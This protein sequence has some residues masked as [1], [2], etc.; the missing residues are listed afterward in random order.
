[1]SGIAGWV[2]YVRELSHQDT[3]VRTMTA[4]MANRGPDHERVWTSRDAVLG[5]RALYVTD[6]E[7][8]PQPL[9]VA[10]DSDGRTAVVT[11][12][13]QLYNGGEL[14]TE[15]TGR[16]HGF[17]TRDD[18]EVIAHAYLEWGA[19]CVERFDGMFAIAIWDEQSRELVLARDRIGMKTLF[20]A[21]Q[22]TGVVFG[23]ERKTVLAHPQVDPVVDRRGLREL[24]SLAA[25]P[26]EAIFQGMRQ[27][28]PGELVRVRPKG[29]S[30]HQ[31]WALSSHPHTDDKDTTVATILELLEQSVD[32]H[33]PHDVPTGTLLSGGVDSSTVTA[34]AAKKARERAG[35]LPRAF[36]VSFTQQE[37]NF[38]ADAIWATRDDPFV[39]DVVKHV[40]IELTT[41][42]LDTQELMDPLPRLATLYAKDLPNPLGNMNTSLYLL[43]RQVREQTGVVLHGDPSDALFGGF[44]WV[45]QPNIMNADTLP[46]VAR[47]QA[48]GGRT[49]FGADLLE[50]GLLKEL[51]LATYSTERYHEALA[52]MPYRDGETGLDRKMREVTYLH[53][54]RWLEVLL[55]QSE[56][57]SGA[58]GLEV[59]WPY[60]D[61]R[62]VEYAFNIPWSMKDCDE[63]GKGLLRAAAANLVP[64]TVLN[65]KKSPF[66]VTHN[67]EYGKALCAEL[68]ELLA[69]PNAP[70]ATLLNTTAAREIIKDPD[71]LAGGSAAFAAR[72]NI[73]MLLQFN[74]WLER[75][76]ISVR[77]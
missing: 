47:A 44:P 26:G 41:V 35:A 55:G 42:M 75:Y 49:G 31:Y 12:A 30:T 28:L 43:C 68:A 34:L 76:R 56:T 53:L 3:V 36:T 58:V 7:P 73:E 13:G 63:R 46:W 19:G 9:V 6:R 60:A 25:T 15:L 64:Q 14:W 70:A 8:Q 74:A 69:D 67:P 61:H 29:I 21:A 38:Q 72:S 17:H 4:T 16:G 71:K 50:A 11:Y 22:H 2:D 65:R 40:G 62:L 51:D 33:L 45:F 20:Y 32:R 27:V 37:E 24:F 18:A 77:L 57:M 52:G 59:R 10:R 39:A 54:T 48:A 66:P 1:M 5:H 23:S